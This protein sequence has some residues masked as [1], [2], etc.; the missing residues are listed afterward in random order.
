V[1]IAAVV[2]LIL[3]L[4]GGSDTSTASGMSEEIAR[5]INDRDVE[6]AKKLY[7]DPGSIKGADISEIPPAMQAKARAGQGSENGETGTAQVIVTLSQGGKTQ[8]LTIDFDLKKKDGNWCITGAKTDAGGSGSAPT[9]R[10][11]PSGP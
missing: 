6:G 4:T 11:R 5:V 2:V 1:V 9:G 10:V 8:D 3:V 7:C